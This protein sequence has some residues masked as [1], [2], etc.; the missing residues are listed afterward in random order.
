MAMR[1]GVVSQSAATTSELNKLVGIPA[2]AYQLVAERV[3]F[4]ETTG[5]G[6]YTASVTVPAG[7]LI[8]DI[9]VWATVLFT[10]TTSADMIVGDA[11]DPNGW[12]D[13]INMKATD[14]AV[15]EQINFAFPGGEAADVVGVYRVIATGEL[16]TAYAAAARVITGEIITVGAAGNAGRAFMEVS[17]SAPVVV[18][19]A[20]KT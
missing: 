5:A 6:T 3:S 10:A 13:A 20:V 7:A 19:A 4:T 18:T 12:Y 2:L 16:E 15:G 14:L 17:Y 11:A 1:K 9:K 8:Y